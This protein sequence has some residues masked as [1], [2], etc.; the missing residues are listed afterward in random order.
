MALFGVH[1]RL[2]RMPAHDITPGVS[3]CVKYDKSENHQTEMLRRNAK[4]VSN[5]KIITWSSTQSTPDKY[6]KF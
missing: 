1:E 2:V 5:F 3:I 6:A 4:N